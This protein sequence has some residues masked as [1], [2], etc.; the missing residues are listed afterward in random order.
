[1]DNSEN[2]RSPP[3]PDLLVDALQDRV[4]HEVGKYR[5]ANSV[6]INKVKTFTHTPLPTYQLSVGYNDSGRFYLT[7]E[8]NQY[9]SVTTV[10]SYYGKNKLDEWK[11]RVGAVEAKRVSDEAA[12]VGTI[13]HE[14][15]EYFL[16]NLS[17]VFHSPTAKILFN[18]IRPALD[19]IDN[20][21]LLEA[22]LYSDKLKLA[23]SVDCV[24]EYNGTPSIIDF[25]TSKKRKPEDWIE[26]YFVQ[27][28]IYA[29]MVYELY[30]IRIHQIVTIITCRDMDLQVIVKPIDKT[31]TTLV[32]KY[33]KHYR[34]HHQ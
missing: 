31:L 16:K 28:T 3:S 17:P 6:K 20:I 27:E 4:H 30:D 15:C 25:K 1:M 23:G 9:P 8:G 24:A 11:K 33:I 34:D 14:H 26:N 22:N 18:T 32:Q 13:L 21:L 19:K 12:G 7:P 29:A 5:L 10:T 2:I